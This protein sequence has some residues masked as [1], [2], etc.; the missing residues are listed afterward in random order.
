[1]G[2]ITA[3]GTGTEETWKGLCEGRSGV[4]TITRFDPT[5][6][7]TRIA[8]EV[9]NFDPL[10]WFEKKDVKKMDSFIHYAVA[11]ADCAMRQ[12]GLTITPE[13]AERTG[14]FIGS[15]IGG[16]TIIEREHQAFLEG[17]PRKIS[18]FFIPSSFELKVTVWPVRLCSEKSISGSPNFCRS[19]PFCKRFPSRFEGLAV[20]PQNK[21]RPRRVVYNLFL[22]AVQPS[23]KT[24]AD[25]NRR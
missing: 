15:G 5:Q 23:T 4:S 16:F 6:F 19:I 21:L 1:M 10:Q 25:G 22:L 12:A 2:L 11:A 9:K 17:G 24:R 20:H 13:I 7:S 3:L 18:P 14:V 8:A